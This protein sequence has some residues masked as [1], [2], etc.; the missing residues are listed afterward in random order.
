MANLK[1]HIPIMVNEAVYAMQF[2]TGLKL[3]RGLSFGERE[4]GPRKGQ[5]KEVD[6]V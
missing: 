5:G 4:G 6:M 2:A 1:C 3:P